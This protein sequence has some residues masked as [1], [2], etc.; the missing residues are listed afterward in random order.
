MKLSTKGRYGLRA[1]IDMSWH[2][3]G[4]PMPLVQVAERQGLS[5]NYLEQVFASLRRAGLVVSVKGSLGGY[6]LALAPEQ[7]RVGDVL[8]V[9]EGD[10]RI[11]DLD[12]SGD[13]PR[14]GSVQA[15]LQHVLW[16]KVNEAVL[17]VVDGLSLS[18]L[19]EAYRAMQ[20]QDA[21]MFYI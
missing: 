20:D 14:A 11:T 18:D 4:A 16:D 10:L 6:A 1:L 19:I 7:I 9:L 2:G 15:C 5:E 12:A 13:A 8:R 17:R 3:N 21:T